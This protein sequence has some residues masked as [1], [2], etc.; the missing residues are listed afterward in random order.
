MEGGY[1]LFA[2]AFDNPVMLVDPLGTQPAEEPMFVGHEIIEVSGTAPPDVYGSAVKGKTAK[3]LDT[4][5]EEF[6]DNLA[7]EINSRTYDWTPEGQRQAYE[8]KHNPEKARMEWD[9]FERSKYEKHGQQEVAGLYERYRRMDNAANIGKAI[10]VVTIGA[11]G[12]LFAIQ[13]ATAYQGIAGTYSLA[14]SAN[15]ATASLGGASAATTLL[16]RVET[17]A[18]AAE[19]TL[20]SVGRWMSQKE[21]RLMVRTGQIQEGAGGYTSVSTAGHSDFMKQAANGDYYVQFLVSKADLLPGGKDTWFRLAGE[22]ASS[23][24]KNKVLSQGGQLLPDS[25]LI[26]LQQGFLSK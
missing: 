6:G 11:S 3:P 2:Y 18:P 25:A 23:I 7:A 9:R 16:N 5:E 4:T 26:M 8:W 12:S 17:A 24:F 1:N 10:A 20:V 13:A 15:T 14:I 19:G 21:F 22:G